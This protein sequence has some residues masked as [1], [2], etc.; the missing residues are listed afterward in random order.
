MEPF[1]AYG[2]RIEGG[3]SGPQGNE[4]LKQAFASLDPLCEQGTLDLVLITGD[5]T[6]AGTSAEWAEFLDSVARH[7]FLAERML[8]LPGN[9]DVNIVDSSNPAR[10]DTPI[11]P[12]KT[13]QRTNVTNDLRR[14]PAAKENLPSGTYLP[15]ARRA[16]GNPIRHVFAFVCLPGFISLPKTEKKNAKTS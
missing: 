15:P 4:R 9:H 16:L 2:F 8:L 7:P 10:L 11:S 14:P 13:L 6:D 3:R 1:V 12:N 5:M